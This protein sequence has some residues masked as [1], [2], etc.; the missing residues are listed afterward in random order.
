[1]T[2]VSNLARLI[3]FAVLASLSAIGA[4]PLPESGIRLN[5]AQIIEGGR[6]VRV[7][8]VIFD[9]TRFAFQIIDNAAPANRPRYDDLASAMA[10]RGCVAGC[11]GGFFNRE[12]FDPY[13]LMIANSRAFGTFDPQSWMN[14]LLVIRGDTAGLEPAPSLADRTGITALLQSGP[15][16]IRDGIADPALDPLRQA[17]RTFVCRDDLGTWGIGTSAPCS[18]RELGHLLTQAP[19]TS[20][21]DIKQALNLDGG[22]SSGLWFK[23]TARNYYIR[24]NGPVRNYVGVVPR[25]STTPITP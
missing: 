25:P 15:W 9:A 18:L 11:N 19:V 24:E 7:S 8:L 12:P 21:L 2:A 3:Q 16:L 6:T 5:E 23:Q 22:P 10:D 14:G 13:G 17:R 4:T 1:M 20:A